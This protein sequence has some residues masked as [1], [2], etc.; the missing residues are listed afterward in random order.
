ILGFSSTLSTNAF[1]GGFRYSPTT[2]AALAANSGSVAHAPRPQALQVDAFPAQHAPDRMHARPKPLG[3]RNAVPM[4]QARRWWLF[5]QSQHAVAKRGAVSRRLPWPGPVAETAQS[6]P[7]KALPP[8]AH[9][10]NRRPHLTGYLL[11]FLSFQAGQHQARSLN[12]ARLLRPASAHC[13]Q[14]GADLCRALQRGSM[15]GHLPNILLQ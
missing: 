10:R 2:S 5:E 1:S 11:D 14:L 8:L 7:G 12:H 6:F 9:C 13:D 4:A 3:H 15:L